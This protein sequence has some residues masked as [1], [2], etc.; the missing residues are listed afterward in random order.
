[1]RWKAELLDQWRFVLK[2]CEAL[3][4]WVDFHFYNAI[5]DHHI[6]Q[7]WFLWTVLLT[8]SVQRCVTVW[9]TQWEPWLR[10]DSRIE[11]FT[12]LNISR[13][14]LHACALSLCLCL[15]LCDP[16]TVATRLLCPW[17][18]P[19]KNIGEGCYFL[20]QGIFLTQGSNPRLLRLPHWPA[21][22]F[23]LVPLEPSQ[24]AI[25]WSLLSSISHFL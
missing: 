9:L 24:E 11:C 22:S 19:G 25:G 23:A 12:Y 3:R 2:Q 21:C 1:M 8:V 17:D 15:T 16:R 14:R 10:A 13:E 7:C 5:L 6:A 18:S 20:L 4:L